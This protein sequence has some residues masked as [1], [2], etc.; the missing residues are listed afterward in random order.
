MQ[1]MI[2]KLQE[3]LCSNT[4][5]ATTDIAVSPLTTPSAVPV[6][7]Q[8]H[9]PISQPLP[10]TVPAAEHP[11]PPSSKP[12]HSLYAYQLAYHYREMQDRAERRAK[13]ALR[14]A[15]REAEERIHDVERE[16][17]LIGFLAAN[18]QYIAKTPY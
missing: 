2:N 5:A 14:R 7:V 12:P 10:P 1:K 17:D 8:Q 18:G 15:E 16:R 13:E 6:S 3:K 4:T 9:A 11:Y